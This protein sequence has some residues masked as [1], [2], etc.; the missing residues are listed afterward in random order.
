MLRFF[1]QIRKT[2]MKQNKVRTYLLYAVGEIVL[3]MIGILLAL[4]VNNW[5]E[6]NKARAQEKTLKVNLIESVRSAGLDADLFIESEESN[7]QVL[8]HMLKNWENLSYDDIEN[9]F[10]PF[11]NNNFSPLYN[12]SGYSQFYDPETDIYSTAVNDGSISIIQD[13]DLLQLLH[14]LYNYVVPR[15]NELMEEEYTLSRSINEHIAVRYET[16]FLESSIVDS[17]IIRPRL[18]TEETYQKLFTEMSNDGV[19]KYKLSQRIEFKRSRLLIMSQAKRI[20][21]LIT[22]L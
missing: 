17:T 16:L 7:I 13:K 21:E 18:W 14:R 6:E 1:R 19:L 15:V 12:L 9:Q 2:L 5:N 8:E 3:V 20:I 4:Q 10:R 22:T 11:Q